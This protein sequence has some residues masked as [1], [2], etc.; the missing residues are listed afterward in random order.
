[1]SSARWW[2]LCL[3]E[4]DKLANFDLIIHIDIHYPPAS[5]YIA[6]IFHPIHLC[7]G[8]PPVTA[9]FPSQIASIKQ[10]FDVSFVFNLHKRLNK[11]SSSWWVET[12][13]SS[14]NGIVM[15][16]P[17]CWQTPFSNL[18]YWMK[19]AE[20]RL[21]FQ[22]WF[23]WWFGA[24]QATSHYLNQWW[25]DYRAIYASLGLNELISGL[26]SIIFIVMQKF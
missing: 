19:M 12:P 16:P 17:S 25:L 18:F 3:S 11:Q 15:H 2:P 1:M 8:N 10:S 14:C 4:C 20:Y 7:E 21:K 6:H 22:H 24:Y 9:V 5:A 13:Y 23:R 26:R